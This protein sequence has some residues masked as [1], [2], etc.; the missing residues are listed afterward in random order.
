[1]LPGHCRRIYRVDQGLDDG[2]V[3]RVQVVGQLQRTL[4]V[5]KV[6]VVPWKNCF[7][8]EL[9][10]L[11]LVL[12]ELAGID[13]DVENHFWFLKTLNFV[14]AFTSN[15]LSL[16]WLLLSRH[17]KNH[18]KETLIFFNEKKDYSRKFIPGGA[19]IQSFQPTSAKSTLRGCLL[20]IFRPLNRFFVFFFWKKT[21]WML[22]IIWSLGCLFVFYS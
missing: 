6:G 5:T 20:H 17:K 9:N 13:Y 11:L 4:A 12:S 10:E 16:L 22:Q 14:F 15:L 7:S 8:D 2:V 18:F 21:K 19:T 3:G 1:M